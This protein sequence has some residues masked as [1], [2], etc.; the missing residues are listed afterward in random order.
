MEFL[1]DA[2]LSPGLA[3]HLRNAGH[4]ALHVADAGMRGAADGR[5]W[6]FALDRGAVI[7]TK[8]GDFAARARATAEGPAVV[9][10]RFGNTTTRELWNRLGP[11][12][13]DIS[14]ALE[15]GERIIEI[16]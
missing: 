14:R 12:I 4:S 11:L 8:D 5:I 16:R 6:E 10:I 9:W 1:L 3:A 7:V 2:Q 13:A 15:D